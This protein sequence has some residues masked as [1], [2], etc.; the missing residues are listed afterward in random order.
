MVKSTNPKGSQHESTKYSPFT[1]T[2][3]FYAKSDETQ[4]DLDAIRKPLSEEELLEKYDRI[5]EKGRFTDGPIERSPA[6]GPRP[7]LVYEYKGYTRGPHGWRVEPNLLKRIDEAGDLGWT[8][9]GKPYRKIRPESDK[10]DPIG[11]FWDDIS[12]LNSQ[13]ERIGYPT[14]KP[15]S[16]IERIIEASSKEKDIAAEI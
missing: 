3:L 12:L 9:N 8:S 2:I 7:T 11:D 4:I 14:Q 13:S 5:D 15:R 6:M 16:L 10:G 1:D